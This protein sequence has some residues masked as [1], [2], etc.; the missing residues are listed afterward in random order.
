M[1]QQTAQLNVGQRMFTLLSA[2]FLFLTVV[3]TAQGQSPT[4]TP[5]P[6]PS[7]PTDKAIAANPAQM[8]KDL[9]EK[10]QQIRTRIQEIENILFPI[11]EEIAKRN[12][13]FTSGEYA[14]LRIQSETSRTSSRFFEVQGRVDRDSWDAAAAYFDLAYDALKDGYLWVGREQSLVGEDTKLFNDLQTKVREE[15]EKRP[16]AEKLL[17][18]ITERDQLRQALQTSGPLLKYLTERRLWWRSYPD[19]VD[20]VKK[21]SVELDDGTP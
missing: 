20:T 2:T 17:Q 12:F 3:P 16:D 11:E 13:F 19:Y 14:F 7:A 18:L 6:T 4:A 1:P 21:D 8:L 5:T 10:N 15:M 9:Q